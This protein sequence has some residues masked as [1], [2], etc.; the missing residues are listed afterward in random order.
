MLSEEFGAR[1]RR[2]A[3]QDREAA[4]PGAERGE[5]T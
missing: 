1:R 5:L 2:R 4:Y 3:F